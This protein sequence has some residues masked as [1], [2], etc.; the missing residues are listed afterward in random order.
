MK[1]RVPGLQFREN[2]LAGIRPID[3]C[4][5]SG[6]VKLRPQQILV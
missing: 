5:G 2:H 1:V 3:L 4:G 6:F